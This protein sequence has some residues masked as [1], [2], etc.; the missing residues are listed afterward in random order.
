MNGYYG[1]LLDINMVVTPKI[2]SNRSRENG[3]IYDKKAGNIIK[4][5]VKAYEGRG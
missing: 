4:E 2:T 3:V 5:V 1:D